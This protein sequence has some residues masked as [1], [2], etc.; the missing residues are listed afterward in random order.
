MGSDLIVPQRFRET[1]THSMDAD[2]GLAWISDPPQGWANPTDCGEFPCTAPDNLLIIDE[3]GGLINGG[4]NAG[5]II[6]N[7]R[8]VASRDLCVWKA[9]MNVFV[10]NYP[11]GGNQG[12]YGTLMFES[13]DGDTMERTLSPIN[14]TAIDS[15]L[16]SD[17]TKYFNK[18]NSFMDHVWDGFYTGQLR[19]S[20]FMSLVQ[21]GREFNVTYTSTLPTNMR[22]QLGGEDSPSDGVVVTVWNVRPYS[23][24]VYK[25]N[26]LV[27]TLR[28]KLGVNE[29][30]YLT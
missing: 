10:C 20:R 12:R 6:P 25:N 24:H 9:K 23:V 21:F 2:T 22:Y 17:S 29:D 8:G 4:K 13:L 30:V 19:L 7:N 28:G 16:N 14:V 18:L 1:T 15:V 11:T 5:A 3:D 27:P 26:F